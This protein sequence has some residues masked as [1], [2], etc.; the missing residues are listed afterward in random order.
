[1]GEKYLQQYYYK[2]HLFPG[3]TKAGRGWCRIAIKK[4]RI[5]YS[6]QKPSLISQEQR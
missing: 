2:K 3:N 1:M 4:I 5:G 6:W